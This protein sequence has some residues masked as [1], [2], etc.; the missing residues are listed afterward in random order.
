M[1][2]LTNKFARPL[3]A[4]LI[5]AS[6]ITPG[7]LAQDHNPVF[8]FPDI[9]GYLTLLCDFHMHT[10]FSDGSVWPNIRV[11][12]AQ[13]H[14]LD[15]ISIT[16]HLEYQPKKEDVPHADRNRSYQLAKEAAKNSDLI[17]VN[18]A[19]IT[20]SMPPGHANAIFLKDANKL[21]VDDYMEAFRE[22]KAQGAFVFW[23]HPH[24]TA[25]RPD[26]VAT[27]TGL[28]TEL[29]EEGLLSG[30]EIYN[31]TTYSDEALQ[32]AQA[33]HL[34]LIGTSDMHGLMDWEYDTSEGEHR[35]VTL[36]FATE[37]SEQA[38]KEAMEERRTAVWF[39]N[40][41]VGDATYVGPL[42][43]NSLEL[44]HHV[45]SQVQ[46][47]EIINHSDASYILE[48]LSGYTLHNKASVF[49]LEAHSSINLQVKTP[50]KPDS[51]D[52]TFR[53]LN[54]FSAPSEHPEISFTLD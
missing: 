37:K 2:T 22:A 27:L 3:L 54:A 38:L 18:G 24:W 53:V 12:E 32:I 50:E 43:K 5:F 6:G 49:I 7:T 4:I 52:L 11:Q 8:E 25:Q 23:N 17:V 36:V 31:H 10:V 13:R 44:I 15:A 45:K 16:D 20:R 26:G 21:N 34:A 46:Q 29:I 41:L 28:H 40:T 33:H 51:F 47:I 9:P 48:N 39:D 42:V 35:P 14:G 1:K 19:E 30:I